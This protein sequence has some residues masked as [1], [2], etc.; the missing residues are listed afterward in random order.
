MKKHFNRLGMRSATALAAM[1]LAAQAAW[2]LEPFK[3]Q[4]IRVEGLQRVEAG[5]VFASMPLRVG[6]DYNDEKGA[7]AIRSLFA[8]GLFKDVRLEANGNVLVVVVEERPTIAEVNFAGTKEFDKDTLLKAMRDVGLADGRPF[9]KALADRAEQELKRQY[10]NRS[11]YGAE[12]V[13]TVTPIERNRVNLTFTVSEGEPAKINEIHIVGNKAFKESTLKD[14]FDQDTGNWMSW[15][16][17]SDRYARNKLNADLESLRSYYLQRGY[18]EFRVE[19]TQVAIS[20][21]KQNIGLTVNIHEGNQ[22]VVSGVKLDG[23]YLDRDDEFKSL[24]KIKP[25]EPY[26]AD[27]VSE[28]VKAF[29]DYYSNFGFAFAKVEAVPEIDRANNR[30]AIVLQAQPS[31]RA[32]IR[33]ISVSGNNKTRD[34]VIRREFRQFEASW[35]DGQKIK[36]SRDRVDRLGFFTQVDIETQEVPGS[37]DQVDLMINVVE[38]PTGSIQLGAGFSS[39]EK[40][41]LSFGIKQENVFGSGNYLG[42]D[43]NTSKYN[44]TMV[45]ST[46]NPYFTDTGISRTYDL[47]YRTV[48]PY[49]D[50]GAYKII[51][52]GASVRFGVPF[53]EV[54][55]IFFGAGVEGNEIKPGTYMPEVYN[56]YCG[57]AVGANV[58][59]SKTGIPLTLGWSR[60]NRDSALAPNSGRYQRVNLEA[61]FMSDMRYAKANYQIQQYIPLNKKYTIALNGELGWGKGLGGNPYPIF[62]NFY[63][64]GLGSVRGFEQ[65]SLGRRDL[66]NTNLALGGTRK[67]TLNGEFMVPFPGAGNDRTL[68]LF[69]FVDVGNVWAEGESMDLGT[70]RASTGIGISW[71]SPLGPLRLAYAQP[72]RKETGDRIQKLQFQIGTSF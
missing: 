13:T 18:L 63:S 54:D 60:D 45:V 1:V 34:E 8:L 61:S 11:L 14:L 4:D 15:Y 40:V 32:Y 36:L 43:V 19:S 7:A 6:D 27:Q 5:T 57:G 10:I 30:V 51:T 39:A 70:L 17:K 20:P 65:G 23:N 9:D 64:G 41:S 24:V 3:V 22:Y 58:G 66:V 26:N 38:K 31:R 35:Y 12:V 48:R 47:Y 53:S 62:K 33:R 72:I 28:T 21:D 52:K 37:P 56:E 50:D 29:T 69:G 25:G 71:I 55:T 46:T 59:C 49:Y 67:L 42:L 2:A 16:T 44:R 68:R